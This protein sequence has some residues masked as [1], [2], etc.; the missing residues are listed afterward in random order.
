MPGCSVSMCRLRSSNEPNSC[1]SIATLAQSPSFGS[2][3][4]FNF[5][6]WVLAAP[7]VLK[8]YLLERP[9]Q[10]E[11]PTEAPAK[12]T[13]A[14]ESV[15]PKTDVIPPKMETAPP[16]ASETTPPKPAIVGPRS[17]RWRAR[18][19]STTLRGVC[20]SRTRRSS[21]SSAR[22]TF[23]SSAS[24]R[25]RNRHA[26]ARRARSAASDVRG[27]V[28]ARDRALARSRG[29]AAVY[30]PRTLPVFRRPPWSDRDP[31]HRPTPSRRLSR[32]SNSPGPD[33]AGSRGRRPEYRPR[34]EGKGI[35]ITRTRII[36]VP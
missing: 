2:A 4:A 25:R 7:E 31:P 11:I 35:N 30:G 29:P 18:S 24:S 27:P 28:H 16:P 34:P 13:P 12:E 26:V 20:P 9:R 36:V 15:A 17:R 32:P 14:E 6:H 23:V 21:R 19:A 8:A 3:V 33:P 5:D 10:A 1:L 22:T